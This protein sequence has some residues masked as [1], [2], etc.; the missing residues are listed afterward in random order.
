MTAIAITSLLTI[1]LFVAVFMLAG[2][3]PAARRAL[4]AA[5]QAVQVMRDPA[6][7]DLAREKAVQSAA[8]QVSRITL[9]LIVKVAVLL[10]VTALPALA[11]DLAGLAPWTDTVGFLSRWDVLLGATII[12]GGLVIGIRRWR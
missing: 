4:Q 3:I 5:Q 11:A 7:D 2:L 6:L 8:V 10:A 1:I 12:V 9:L